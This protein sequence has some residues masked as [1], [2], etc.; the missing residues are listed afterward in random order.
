MISFGPELVGRTEKTLVALLRRNLAGTGLDE[1]QYVTLK[2]ASDLAPS[3]DLTEA[4]R[5]RAHFADAAQLVTALTDSGLLN[6]G[7]LS[8]AGA[9]LLDQILTSSAGQSAV[10][11]TD[12]HEDDV[13]ATTRVLN[14]VMARAEAALAR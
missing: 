3:H 13:A 7:R 8:A 12:I 14:L 10:I 1:Q 6:D 2:V 4:L 11:W 9:T 5:E